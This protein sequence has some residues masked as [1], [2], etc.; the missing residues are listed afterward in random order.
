MNDYETSVEKEGK[1]FDGEDDPLESEVISI[2]RKKY[3]EQANVSSVG[4]RHDNQKK[5]GELYD[6]V[7]H[8]VYHGRNLDAKLAQTPPIR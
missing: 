1:P 4:S 6:W 8:E 3:S 2:V 7:I 5:D